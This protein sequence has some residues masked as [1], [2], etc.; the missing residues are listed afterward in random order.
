MSQTSTENRL[1]TG[2]LTSLCSLDAH[3]ALSHFTVDAGISLGSTIIA[4]GTAKILKLLKR[5][6]ASYVSVHVQPAMIWTRYSVSVV[7]ADVTCDLLDGSRATFPVTA[8]L[9]F[10][11][12]LISDIRLFTYEPA[13]P[14]LGS[15]RL[16]AHLSAGLRHTGS[17]SPLA[18]A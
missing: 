5:S 4:A 14:Q 7:E 11:D 3:L 8:I 1:V 17:A 9:C 12:D 16:A 15:T 2:F 13:V 6:M 18:P 10:R